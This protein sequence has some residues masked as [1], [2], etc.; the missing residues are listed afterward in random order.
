MNSAA[1]W[2]SFYTG[3]LDI[4]ENDF[5]V[6]AID[7]SMTLNSV[8]FNNITAGGG[9]MVFGLAGNV[10]HYGNVYSNPVN[11]TSNSTIDLESTGNNTVQV[12]NLTINGG[13]TLSLTEYVWQRDA[14]RHGA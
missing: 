9:L 11:V 2:T 4:Y 7:Q 8:T 1:G 12:G 5:T 3:N 6:P 14:L 10:I 13:N